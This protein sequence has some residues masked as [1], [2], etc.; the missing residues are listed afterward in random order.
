VRLVRRCFL[1]AVVACLTLAATASA[2]TDPTLSLTATGAE[3][4][5]P[6]KATATLADGT[7]P[8]GTIT[9]TAYA[10]GDP[11][12][13]A[14][15]VFTSTVP[16]AGNADYESTE[17]APAEAGTYRWSAVYSGD[18]ENNPKEALCSATSAIAQA[19][20]G[21][22]SVATNATIGASVSDSATLAAAVAPTGTITFKAF[23]PENATCAGG[24]AFESSSV[25]NGNGNYGSGTFTATTAGSYRWTVVYSGD[26]NNEAATS[27]CNAP[28][29]T[30]TVAKATPAIST[31]ATSGAIGATIA[32]S[33]SISAGLAPTG[34]ITFKAFGPEN[35]TCTGAAAFEDTVTVNGNGIY[36]SGNF[37]PATAGTYRWT[38][39]YSGDANNEAA[40]SVCNAA[41]ETS[42]VSK[43][44]PTLSTTAS[45]A[46]LGAT[47]A[48]SA[49]LGAGFSPTGTIT[50]KVFGPEDAT[51]TGTPAFE[52]TVN[53]NGAGNYGSGNF[54]PTAAG[55]YRWTATY[56]GDAS[57]NAATSAC[58]AANETSTVGKA[59]PA[60]AT[61]A[62]NATVGAAIADSGALSAGVAPTGTVTFK[63]FGPENATCTGTPA[64]EATIPVAGNGNY[65]SG[66]F[67][68]AAAGTY[69]WTA[70]YSGDANNNAATSPC[71]SANET[72]TVAKAAPGLT[73]N[74]ANAHYPNPVADTATLA[75][76]FTPTGT[77]LFKAFGPNNATCAG[78]PAFE[79][80]VAVS[81]NGNYGSTDFAATQLGAYRWTVAYSGD[82]NNATAT[83]ACNAANGTSTVQSALP[84]LTSVASNATIGSPIADTA[85]LAGGFSPTGTLLFKAFGPNNPGCTGAA[86]FEATVAVNGNGT[87]GSGNF[88]SGPPPLGEY[89]WTVAY[90][91]DAGNEVATSPCN[92]PNETSV[93]SKFSPALTLSASPA[94][95]GSSIASIVNLSG[96][97]GHTGQLTFRAFAPSDLSCTGA[98]VFAKTVDVT[99]GNDTY[100]SGAFTPAQAGAYRW[101][102][103]YTG[104][105]LNAPAATLCNAAGATSSV[106]PM[107][108]TLSAKVTAASQPIGT[109]AKDTAIL[110]GGY[111][112]GGIVTFR[113]YGP[114][115]ATCS[116]PPVFASSATVTANGS[117]A[118]EDVA[119]AKAGS[120]V[121]SVAYSGDP[122]NRAVDP[123]CGGAEQ[124]LTVSKR[125]PTLSAKLSLRGKSRLAARAKLAGAAAPKGKLL[126]Q[127]F[128]PNDNRCTG[129]PVLSEK[130]AVHGGGN[131]HPKVFRA[132]ERGLYRL[133]VSYPGDDWNLPARAACNKSGQSVRVG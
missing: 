118:S 92:A 49:A 52:A 128:G 15:A 77:I 69:R 4:G 66:N 26:T 127:L 6:V 132:L 72:S 2:V 56:S 63:A 71:N 54:S 109:A 113:L 94:G 50:F 20:P 35:A 1:L 119:P 40:T 130:V 110:A 30:S 70:S 43:V 65:P 27:P 58:N 18:V 23:G 37:S 80:S 131:L 76:G 19:T 24:A 122:S 34:T 126:F 38:A 114:G 85:T 36:G 101:T 16:V 78:S 97:S 32:D 55:A 82:A 28:N 9:F 46:T 93:V 102:A 10:P 99:A 68:P 62:S 25:V 129:K 98:G 83:S 79:K 73:S 112:P 104:D 103:T 64:F 61:T 59:S 13:L 17:F 88:S 53:V 42:T 47:I 117:Y 125:A 8:T 41:N 29:E 60:L 120:Y 67:T 123:V 3:V 11:T 106:S 33:A 39:S 96:G 7:D 44:L 87:Y 45:N 89:R 75:G 111:Q 84:T 48:D 12:C 51:C 86:A 121:F 95:I 90:S 91:G 57:N 115:D 133:V 100:A 31:T 81:G 22:T 107:S 116:R 21:I 74:A 14:T 5:L 124:T 108:P 105:S